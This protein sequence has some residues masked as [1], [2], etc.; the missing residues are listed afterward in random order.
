M[1]YEVI[2]NEE[3]SFLDVVIIGII[4]VLPLKY[5]KKSDLVLKSHFFPDLCQ[6]RVKKRKYIV[7]SANCQIK[8]DVT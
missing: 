3:T 5:S 7:R 1:R 6:V 8:K 2:L 4:I